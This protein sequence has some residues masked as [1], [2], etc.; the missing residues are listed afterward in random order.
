MRPDINNIRSVGEPQT[1]YRWNMVLVT[2]PSVISAPSTEDLNVRCV[3]TTLPKSTNNDAPLTIRGHTVETI[4]KQ[5][6]ERRITLI[7][8]ET[9]D[10]IIAQFF[11]D[12]RQAVWKDITGVSEDKKDVEAVIKLER[13]NNKDEAVW[14]YVMTGCFPKDFTLPQLVEESDEHFKPEI[15]LSYD[16][17]REGTP[18]TASE[19]VVA[20]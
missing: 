18:G 14:E 12:W 10:N 16:Y 13:L 15:I 4:G 19:S 6:Y 5:T 7:F 9:V 1:L 11:S 3:S 17:F 2:P 20:A 8:V